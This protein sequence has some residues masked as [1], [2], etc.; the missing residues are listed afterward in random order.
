M[1]SRGQ[2]YL[3]EKLDEGESQDDADAVVEDLLGKVWQYAD[4]KAKGK[5]KANSTFIELAYERYDDDS[6]E[7]RIEQGFVVDLSDGTLFSTLK[8]RPLAAL[9]RV[10]SQVSYEDVLEIA[11]AVVYPGFANRRIRWELASQRTRPGTPDDW[12][13][14]HA[15]AQPDLTAALAK[16]K[17]QIKNPLAPDEAVFLVRTSDVQRTA[18]GAPVLIDEKGGKLALG[19]SPIARAHTTNNLVMAA[20]AALD[21]GKLKGPASV[22]VRLWL[23]LEDNV[24]MGQP[25]ALVIGNSHM[26]LGM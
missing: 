9:D 23:G 20:G 15:I 22:L 18:G 24:V 8:Y 1:V 14:L 19:D 4:L 13:K 26:R 17:E 10:P 6:R 11:E 3:D 2:K 5:V 7:E 16:L 25:L 12:K 21:N